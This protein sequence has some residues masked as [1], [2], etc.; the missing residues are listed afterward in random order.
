L[1]LKLNKNKNL[2]IAKIDSTENDIEEIKV[3]GFP[4]FYLF[5]NGKKNN[6]ILFEG[7]RT[8]EGVESFLK[9]HTSY[10]WIE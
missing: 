8:L 1:A 4:T 6:P 5:V 3:E 9:S 10:S 2:V 7:E